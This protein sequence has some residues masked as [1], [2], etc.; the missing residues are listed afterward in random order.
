MRLSN[1]KIG[2]RISIAVALPMVGLAVFMG[3][4][5]TGEFRLAG[6]MARIEQLS[7]FSRDVSTLIHELQRERRNSAGFVGAQ[8]E[9][10]FRERPETPRVRTDAAIARYLDG[11]ATL[12]SAQRA[13]DMDFPLEHIANQLSALSAHRAA[14][15]RPST[16]MNETVGPYTETVNALIRVIEAETQAAKDGEGTI[17]TMVP[18]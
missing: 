18:S 9:G 6:Q 3:F 14:I 16:D 7:L 11:A 2:W 8:G 10:E 1:F 15:S 5:V 17:A 13:G 12:Q 4:F